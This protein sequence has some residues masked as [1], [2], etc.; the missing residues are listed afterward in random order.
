MAKNYISSHVGTLTSQ[1]KDFSIF[2]TNA[3]FEVLSKVDNALR[4][5]SS[6][7]VGDTTNVATTNGMGTKI[8]NSLIVC[9]PQV[10]DTTTTL[11][12][13]QTLSYVDVDNDN[14]YSS[15]DYK[16]LESSYTYVSSESSLKYK[17][18]GQFDLVVTDAYGVP[19]CLTPPFNDIDT[20]YFTVKSSIEVPSRK[21]DYI[22]SYVM[23]LSDAFREN[24]GAAND[25]IAKVP[26]SYTAIV[27]DVD[28][29]KTFY[30][31]VPKSSKNNQN[32][33]EYYVGNFNSSYSGR[34]A[35]IGPGEKR[36]YKDDTSNYTIVEATFSYVLDMCVE[37]MQWKED[38]F[39]PKEEVPKIDNTYIS[40]KSLSYQLAYLLNCVNDLNNRPYE[41]S[42]NKIIDPSNNSYIWTGNKTDYSGIMKDSRYEKYVADTT[43]I[44]QK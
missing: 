7:V 44:L 8:A 35:Y 23:T 4:S 26:Y 19:A 39:N 9:A 15:Y 38:N 6:Q 12:Y 43:F 18:N 30:L 16:L 22:T 14:Q 1:G 41:Y 32:K 2:S 10:K 20:S 33:R 17:D 40:G 34:L 5:G 24:I 29:K 37:L 11:T 27:P 3:S 42:L 21:R 28:D 13:M 25:Y 36:I 31:I